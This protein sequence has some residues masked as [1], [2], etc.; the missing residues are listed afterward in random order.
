MPKVCSALRGVSRGGGVGLPAV[1]GRP[2][3]S[4]VPHLWHS[5]VLTPGPDPRSVPG[6]DVP[7]ALCPLTWPL[8]L[9]PLVP[10]PPAQPT[11]P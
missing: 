10:P 11:S 6:A 1:T 4:P 7:R 5:H 9:M 8:P 2:L 3:Y